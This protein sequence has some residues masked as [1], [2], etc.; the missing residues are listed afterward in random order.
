[1]EMIKIYEHLNY[2]VYTEVTDGIGVEVTFHIFKI[3]EPL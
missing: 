3:S 2:I 1:M